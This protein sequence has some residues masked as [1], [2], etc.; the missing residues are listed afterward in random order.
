MLRVQQ[1][2]LLRT[3]L[4]RPQYE[5][6]VVL[7]PQLLARLDE[8][9]RYPLVLVSAPAGFG[10][11]TLLS[12]WLEQC[13]LPSTWLSLDA[14]DNDLNVFLN[15]FIAAVRVLQ[16]DACAETEAL[17]RLATPAPETVLAHQLVNDLDVLQTNFVLVLDDYDQIENPVIHDLMSILVRRPRARYDWCWQRAAIRRCQWLSCVPVG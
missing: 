4:H 2:P 17:A 14:G 13:S 8:G 15:Y 12:A 6:D 16:P 7:R 9:L 3:K 10:K 11:T 5:T 1:Q